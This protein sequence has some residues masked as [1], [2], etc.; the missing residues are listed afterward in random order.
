MTAW[1]KVALILIRLV[2]GIYAELNFNGMWQICERMILFQINQ[3]AFVKF[4]QAGTS[5]TLPDTQRHLLFSLSHMTRAI[6][7]VA[8]LEVEMNIKFM[9]SSF[10]KHEKATSLKFSP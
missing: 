1:L 4:R 9:L 10:E 8:G 6:T 3:F 7:E 2:Y 5:F